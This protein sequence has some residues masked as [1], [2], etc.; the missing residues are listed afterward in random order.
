MNRTA[1]FAILK[2]VEFLLGSKGEKWIAGNPKDKNKKE[3]LFFPQEKSKAFYLSLPDALLLSCI[4]YYEVRY[5]GV[6]ILDDQGNRIGLFSDDRLPYCFFDKV[7]KHILFSNLLIEEFPE[8]SWEE[9][10]RILDNAIQDTNFPRWFLFLK[11]L[12]KNPKR[13]LVCINQ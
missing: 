4:S 7:R 1:K 5:K 10:K 9:T 12:M 2:N 13:A 11:K 6:E 3:L 8:E